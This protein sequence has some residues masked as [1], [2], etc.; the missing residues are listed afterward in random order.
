MLMEQGQKLVSDTK[1]K[2]FTWTDDM[3]ESWCSKEKRVCAKI[4]IAV[5]LGGAEG[6]GTPKTPTIYERLLKEEVLTDLTIVAA[7]GVA[8]RCHRAFLGVQSPVLAAILQGDMGKAQ[9]AVNTVEMLEM[10]EAAVKA[11]LAFLYYEEYLE[12]HKNCEIAYQLFE[13]GCKYGILKLKTVMK[14]VIL[15]KPLWWLGAD[16]ALRLF[17][18]IWNLENYG[19]LKM[20]AVGALRA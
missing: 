1:P 12:A 6:M 10:S 17:L 16:S 3:W 19:E 9:G 11:L 18:L 14:T 8:I 20:K 15:D 2:L 7:K 13:A 5:R 4:S